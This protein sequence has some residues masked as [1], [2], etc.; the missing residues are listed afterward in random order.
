MMEAGAWRKD[1]TGGLKN[2][3]ILESEMEAECKF[4]F[5]F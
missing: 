3:I 4:Y 5:M 1:R 2:K